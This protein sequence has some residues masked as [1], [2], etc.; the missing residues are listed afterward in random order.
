ME[1]KSELEEQYLHTAQIT[2]V[3]LVHVNSLSCFILF[4]SL[5][6]FLFKFQFEVYEEGPDGYTVRI[7]GREVAIDFIIWT[8]QALAVW[9]Q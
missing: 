8:N 5:V 4:I 6:S 7:G 9:S 3:F 1:E 2:G